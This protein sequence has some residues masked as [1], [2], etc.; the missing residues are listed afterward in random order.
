MLA[1]A[2]SSAITRE[3]WPPCQ[4]SGELPGL[5]GQQARARDRRGVALADRVAGA[6]VGLVAAGDDD[7]GD[8]ERR[9][10]RP[11]T[12]TGASAASRAARRRARP[13]CAC[14][15]QPLAQHERPCRATPPAPRPRRRRP[16]RSP[17][18]R[19][20]AAPPR[21]RPSARSRGGASGSKAGVTTTTPATRSGVLERERA[22][23]CA[24][25]STRRPAPRAR[26][27]ARRAPRAGRAPA[28]S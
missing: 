22:A 17:P 15:G 5:L 3:S 11:A 12:R 6:G 14:G 24:R 8:V 23:A 26:C 16:R 20:R 25:P 27:R 18:P 21:A 9:Q 10:L 13:R 28:R 7:R 2:A 4:A 19:P 1:S